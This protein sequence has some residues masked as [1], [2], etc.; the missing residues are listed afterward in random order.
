MYAIYENDLVRIVF[1]SI[2]I[3]FVAFKTNSLNEWF[4]YA[5]LCLSLCAEIA[6]LLNPNNNLFMLSVLGVIQ[7]IL[8]AFMISVDCR[9]KNVLWALIPSLLLFFLYLFSDFSIAS[10]LNYRD[11]YEGLKPISVQEFFDLFTIF[12]LTLVILLF[13][14]LNYSIEF[15]QKN[16]LIYRKKLIYIFAFLLFYTGTFFTLAFGRFLLPNL[17][18]WFQ[19]WRMIYFPIYFIFYTTISINLLWKPRHS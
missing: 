19:V 6:T 14:W 1:L 4:I 12:N 10:L 15:Y 18:Q 2:P 13:Y 8:V 16:H 7:T 11:E 17:D 3:I 9:S 5:Y